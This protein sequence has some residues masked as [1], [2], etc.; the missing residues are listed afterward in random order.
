M[1]RIYAIIKESDMFLTPAAAQEMVENCDLFLVHY[2]A[3]HLHYEPNKVYA[4]TIKHHMLWHICW[5]ARWLN[6][7]CMWC[8]DFED[9]CGKMC[10]S[11]KACVAGTPMHLIGAKVCDNFLVATE[12]ACSLR[13]PEP[14][15]S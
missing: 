7:R 1:Y 9:F 4:L 5:M 6:P 13:R 8:Y 12:L 10:R 15:R 14:T 3:L 11:A 2:N